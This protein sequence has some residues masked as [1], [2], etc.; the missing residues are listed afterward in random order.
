MLCDDLDGWDRGMGGRF[1]RESI[2][3][4]IKLFNFVVQQKLTHHCKAITLRE[5]LIKQVCL[6]YPFGTGGFRT[7]VLLEERICRL[8]RN[9]LAS[10]RLDA[11]SCLCTLPFSH[12]CVS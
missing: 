12:L 8:S 5:K 10:S 6:L 7:D 11:M 3:V 9:A 4:Y 2:Y 1:K